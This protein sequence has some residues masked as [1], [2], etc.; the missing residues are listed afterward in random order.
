[1]RTPFTGRLARLPPRFVEAI[2]HSVVGPAAAMS[3][4]S[5]SAAGQSAGRA[6]AAL[7]KRA[8]PQLQQL[9]TQLRGAGQVEAARG[10]RPVVFA[11]AEATGGRESPAVCAV[12]LAVQAGTP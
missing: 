6:D 3:Y 11:G 8:T 7:C 4:L 9:Y 1:M 12:W 10:G 2:F 5:T